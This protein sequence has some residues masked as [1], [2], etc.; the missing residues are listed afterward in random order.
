M[1]E[2]L[3][4]PAVEHLVGSETMCSMSASWLYGWHGA[5]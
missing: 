3:G 1:L 2:V 5:G 4:L